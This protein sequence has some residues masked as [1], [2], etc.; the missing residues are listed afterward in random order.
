MANFNGKKVNPT[1]T[2]NLA[3]GVA[4]KENPKTELASLMVTSFLS[5]DK[6]Y[7]KEADTIKQFEDVFNTLLNTDKLFLAKA[8][9]YARDKFNMRSISH[10]CSALLMESVVAGKWTEPEMKALEHYFTKVTMRP[11]DMSE[12][13]A[14]YSSRPGAYTTKAGRIQIPQVA[15]RG[16][17]AAMASYDEYRMAKYRNED[18]EY[19]LIDVVRMVH[20]KKTPNNA[21]ALEKLVAGTLRS[22]DTWEAKQ[23][24]AGE[25]G[26]KEAVATAKKEAWSEFVAKGERIEYF[27]LLRNLRNLAEQADT[28][29]LNSALDLLDNQKLIK[30]SKVLP[31]RYISA[32][33]AITSAHFS[34][35]KT[36]KIKRALNRAVEISLSN[37]PKFPGTTAIFVDTSGSMSCRVSDNSNVSCSHIA[38]LF[39]SVLYKSNDAIIVQFDDR[40]KIPSL[41]PEDSVFTLTDKIRGCGG[42][43]NLDVAFRALDEKV[44]RIIILSDMQIWKDNCWWNSKPATQSFSDYKKRTG[45]SNC[46]IYSFDLQGNGTLQF[47]EQN[48]FLCAGWSDHSFDILTKM[49][50]DKQYMIKEIEA[51]EL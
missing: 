28:E 44:D 7:Q 51:I 14:A 16:F 49:E 6:Y 11:D 26:D 39:A 1:K 31:F 12:A 8:A 35:V 41:N 32:Y 4:Y 40:A 21:S 38:G 42:G 5:G 29:T 19:S 3:G 13:I 18:K 17:S 33:D 22:V 23:S 34:A 20:T 43:T 15:K 10:L 45:A 37:V 48:V 2:T 47:P 30:R 25:A 50:E 24:K 27:A 36:N 9:I 46:K